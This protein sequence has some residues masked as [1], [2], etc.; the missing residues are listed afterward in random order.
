M[1]RAKRV[2]VAALC[3]VV[4]PV[5]ARADEITASGAGSIGA[6]DIT[7]GQQSAHADPIAPCVVDTTAANRN[8][9]V[10][11]GTTTKYGLGTTTCKRNSN[12]TASVQVSGQ[13][14]ETTVLQQF[15]GPV[16]RAR[17]FKA[18]CDTTENGSSGSMELGSVTGFTVPT[19]IP[20]NY[21][22][23]I[24]G[25]TAGAPPMAEI[26][27]NELVVPNPPD[28]S[29]TTHAMHIKLFPQGGPASGDIVV[30]T[31]ACAPYGG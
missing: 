12:G 19:S 3:L 11:V 5:T 13:R 28:G 6:V 9:P 20:P 8:D 18:G 1:A 27:L 4:V 7:V 23:T 2:V 16:I 31:A 21:T 14:F 26:V 10:S 17:T 25:S 22:V 15:G 24:P 29:L 30:G